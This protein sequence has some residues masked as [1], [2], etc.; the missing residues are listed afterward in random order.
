[1]YNGRYFAMYFVLSVNIERNLPEKIFHLYPVFNMFMA[2]VFMSGELLF[3]YNV[4]CNII[5][6]YHIIYTETLQMI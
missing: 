2:L 3:M 5:F 4:V 6:D 1:M